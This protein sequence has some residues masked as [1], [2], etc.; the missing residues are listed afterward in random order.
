MPSSNITS[1]VVK[2]V[3]GV[4]AALVLGA[5]FLAWRAY[6]A[7]AF[8]Y[9]SRP[10]QV[11]IEDAAALS[12]VTEA[13]FASPTGQVHGWYV[14]SKNGAAIALL[15]GSGGDRRSSLPEAEILS[16]AGYGVLL[17]DMPGHGE[18]EGDV[19]WGEGAR[20]ALGAALDFLREQPDAD[21][22]R[23]GAVGFSMGGLTVA[24]VAASD[25]RL[26]AV[27]LLGA[28]HDQEEHTRWEQRRYG[29]L[30][31]EPALR[32]MEAGGLLRDD[33][34]PVGEVPRITPRALLVVTGDQD[35]VVPPRFT[36]RL[37]EAAGEPKRL[38][39]IEGAGHGDYAKIA[40]DL[41]G[42]SMREFFGEYLAPAE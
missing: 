28:P 42:R 4:G 2:G 14:P 38:L 9:V 8:W 31:Q 16:A 21:P 13:A 26:R 30:T 33:R 22:E 19:D 5:G 32:A 23:L 29:W 6:R 7:E 41:F 17:L 36:R 27:A 37:Y 24:Q 35:G 18:S 34:P 12:G 20:A 39:V 40:P 15:H 3:L 11:P 10:C 1:T 25:A